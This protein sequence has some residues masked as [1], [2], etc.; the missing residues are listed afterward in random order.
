M[1]DVLVDDDVLRIALTVPE[2]VV[3]LHGGTVTVPLREIRSVRVVR[4]V[5]AQ[6]RGLRTPGA[7]LPGVLAIGVWRGV[8]DGRRFQDFVAVHR[9]GPGLVIATSGTY[10]RVLISS[11]DPARLAAELG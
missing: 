6:V 8:V 5:L 1:A 10:D 7:G 9:P 2:R 3:S 11:D 4:D